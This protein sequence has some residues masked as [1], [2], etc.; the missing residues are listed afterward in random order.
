MCSS[1]LQVQAVIAV[2]CPVNIAA[3]KEYFAVQK[4]LTGFDT[5]LT[6]SGEPDSVECLLFGGTREECPKE[7]QMADP[8]NYLS[9]NCPPFLFLHGDMDQ[10]VPIIGTMEF[11]GMMM[12]KIG[13]NNVKFQVVKGARHNIL[14]FE[15]EWI[16]DLE[17]QFLREKLQ[18]IR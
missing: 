13:V 7:A 10:A 6:E 11:A 2:Y 15:E 17:A 1:D 4:A 3:T 12:E 5:L 14:D 18:I 9:E 8:T 16:Y